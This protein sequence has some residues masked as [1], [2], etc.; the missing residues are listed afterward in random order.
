VGGREISVELLGEEGPLGGVVG[1][2]E[3]SAVGLM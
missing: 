2:G 3:R 1:E